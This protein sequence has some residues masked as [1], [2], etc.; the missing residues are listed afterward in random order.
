MTIALGTGVFSGNSNFS[1]TTLSL[2]ITGSAGD[3]LYIICTA[4]LHWTQAATYDN[5]GGQVAATQIGSV[6]TDT[7]NGQ[8][9]THWYVQNPGAATYTVRLNLTSGTGNTFPG[10]AAWPVTGGATSGLLVANGPNQ[11]QA[12]P[13]TGTDAITSGTA[14]TPSGYAALVVGFSFDSSA[15]ANSP[16]AG[17][18]FTNNGTGSAGIEPGVRVISKRITSGT[19]QA[20]FTAQAGQGGAS[21]M[22]MMAA[23][24]ESGGGGSVSEGSSSARR[25]MKTNAVYRMSPGGIYQPEREVVRAYSFAA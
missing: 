16:A 8:T 7:P 17:T 15:G 23:F 22:T 12:A 2:S 24:L 14:Q 13:G 21:Y 19:A 20:T 1:A 5:G 9:N 10:L 11:N 4:D 18:G 25:N 3:S 6:L